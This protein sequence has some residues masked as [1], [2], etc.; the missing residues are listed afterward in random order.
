MGEVY[1]A[2]DT[3]LGREVAIKVLPETF[4]SDSR[5]LARFEREARILASL[6][7]P[8]IAGIHQVE[9]SGGVHFLIMELVEGEDLASRLARGPVPVEAALE[10]ARQVAH[11]LEAAHEKGVVHRDLKPANI[12]LTPE[13]QAK[14]LDFGLARRESA[15]TGQSHAATLT[16]PMTQAG[17]ILG[18]TAYMSPEQACGQPADAQTDIWALGVVL[19]ELLTGRRAFMG[20][21]SSETIAAIIEREPAWELLPERT[22]ALARS[23]LRRCLAKDP[24]HRV[25]NVT[26]AR[27]ELDEASREARHRPSGKS[28]VVTGRTGGLRSA[29]AF[30]AGAALALV[31]TAGW[32]L[33]RREPPAPP[34]IR[35][36]DLSPPTG[37]ELRAGIG[38]GILAISPDGRLV[39]FAGRYTDGPSPPRIFLRSVEQL[40]AKPLV[41]SD[42]G[43]TP[44]FSPD[45]RWIAFWADGAIR[46]LLVDGGEPLTVCQTRAL[47]GASWGDDGT[48]VFATSGGDRGL[49]RVAADGGDPVPLTSP[50]TEGGEID[51]RWPRHL[52]GG[53]GLLYVARTGRLRSR[54]RIMHLSLTT[55]ESRTLW[56]GGEKP[57]YVATGH[58]VYSLLGSVYAVGF[59]SKR[60]ELSGAPVPVL[61]GV[62]SP[63][64]SGAVRLEVSGRGHMVYVPGRSRPP[65][66]DL[67][68]VDRNGAVET[69][70]DARLSF[71]SPVYSPDGAR[72]AV[73]VSTTAEDYDIWVH[74]LA[75]ATASRLTRAGGTH[76]IWSPDGQW[77]VFSSF[78]S[79]FGILRIRSDGSG[80]AEPLT[81]STVLQFPGSITPDGQSLVFMEQTRDAG[82]DISRLALDRGGEP[83]KVLATTGAE[84]QPALSPD[85]RWLAY[86]SSQSGRT[87]VYV[88]P[89]DR[90]GST[91]RVSRSGG[92]SPVWHPAGSELFFRETQDVSRASRRILSVSV[93]PG[94]DLVIGQ[95]RLVAET[96]F[97]FLSKWSWREYDVSPDGEHFVIARPFDTEDAPRLVY[98]PNWLDEVDYTL[99]G[100]PNRGPLLEEF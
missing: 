31:L 96:D 80:S 69:L 76:P 2:E 59:D 87:E 94:P 20:E 58:I 4:A 54:D 42:G 16:A 53:Q 88:R 47:R 19:F 60:L 10:L 61:Q 1:R 63:E 36:F 29:W 44:F 11:G 72:V 91:V 35:R 64:G 89:F 56:T 24:A 83:A 81:S 62:R 51:H 7:H 49:M 12:Q 46:K 18:T 100:A 33:T 55:G 67:V 52:P 43:S 82:W 98:A 85:G 48:I 17:A 86:S 34:E 25:R 66:A 68:A 38:S 39:A 90:P 93:A 37:V 75:A 99:S 50:E 9:E 77:V 65:D 92:A 57:T 14:I 30:L 23:L 45:G 97:D 32:A 8:N 26:D 3:S 73:A 15:S 22:P 40:E 74:D 84:M 78:G 70:L 13:G 5:R 95:P 41:G 71:E 27:L 6:N 28:E 79:Q 21:S